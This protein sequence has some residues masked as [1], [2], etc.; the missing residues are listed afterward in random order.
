[1]PNQSSML[2]GWVAPLKKNAAGRAVIHGKVA[3]ATQKT[4]QAVLSFTGKWPAPLKKRR[5]A[6][7]GLT[8]VVPRHLKMRSPGSRVSSSNFN[9]RRGRSVVAAEIF[10]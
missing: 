2:K 5:Q 1:M 7:A 9:T 6:V 3:G 4:P 8:G 10:P